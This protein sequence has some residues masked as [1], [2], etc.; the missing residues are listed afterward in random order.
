METRLEWYK[1]EE[2]DFA[3]INEFRHILWPTE[4]QQTID[5]QPVINATIGILCAA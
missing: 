3:E 1:V 4:N 2:E 5:H